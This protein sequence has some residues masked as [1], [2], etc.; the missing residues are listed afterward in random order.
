M[1]ENVFI[2][3]GTLFI[4]AMA[5]GLGFAV[6]NWT[7]GILEDTER[8][9]GQQSSQAV[10]CTTID[11]SFI[12]QEENSTHHTVFLQADQDVKSLAVTFYGEEEDATK[13]VDYGAPTSV[14]EVTAPITDVE[15][16]EVHVQGCS[17]TFREQ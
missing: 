13:V 5:L 10:E 7:G 6:F 1:G 3:P 12:R 9:P 14:S 8:G 17:R 2:R 11:V 15:D 16:I 4:F